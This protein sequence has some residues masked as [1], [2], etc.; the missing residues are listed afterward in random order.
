MVLHP[1]HDPAWSRDRVPELDLSP[2]IPGLRVVR[3][4]VP[5]PVTGRLVF[6]SD[7]HAEE[8]VLPRLDHWA[9]AVNDQEPD[10]V[11]FGGD[12][13]RYLACLEPA[14]AFLGRLQARSG[15]LA[16]LG[17]WDRQHAWMTTDAWARA[18]DRAGFRLLVN[19]GTDLAP[20]LRAY[21]TD[22]Y[23]FG[24][25]CLPERRREHEHV[26]TVTHSPDAVGL[27]GSRFLGDLVLSGHTHGG[28]IRPPIGGAVFAS[29][30]FGRQ[31]DYGWRRHS[32]GALLYVTAGLGYTG[33]GPAR[34]RVNCPSEIAV[35][36]LGP[37]G[38]EPVA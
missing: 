35:I 6:V 22:E 12:L 37:D 30:Y 19:Q 32:S 16:V 18:Y 31:F 38:K 13:V 5:A 8:R 34:R 26:I 7:L 1:L 9:D 15:K 23:R 10:W 14:L 24:D 36:D 4:R 3:C 33:V 17:N 21:G 2:A 25:V 11:V 29:S 20:G 27:A 28:Q